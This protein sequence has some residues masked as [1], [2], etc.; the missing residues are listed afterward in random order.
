MNSNDNLQQLPDS[1]AI[2]R[3]LDESLQRV[4]DKDWNYSRITLQLRPLD[5]VDSPY[6]LWIERVDA[7]R[8]SGKAALAQLKSEITWG[9]RHGEELGILE[10]I[11]LRLNKA[12]LEHTTDEFWSGRRPVVRVVKKQE[13]EVQGIAEAF[14]YQVEEVSGEDFDNR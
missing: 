2:L 12:L 14:W 1:S 3:M 6:L 5:Q 10:I 13:L 4:S 9:C 8:Q 7:A 11:S